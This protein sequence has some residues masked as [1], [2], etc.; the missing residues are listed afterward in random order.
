MP[1]R[2]TRRAFLKLAA[3]SAAAAAVP[4]WAATA[5]E[6]REQAGDGTATVAPVPTSVPAAPEAVPT[7]EVP[8]LA[9]LL[10]ENSVVRPRAAIV[11]MKQRRLVGPMLQPGDSLFTQFT[12][13]A[14]SVAAFMQANDEAPEP[15][16]RQS[17]ATTAAWTE[18]RAF[19][20]GNGWG[21]PLGAVRSSATVVV[22]RRRKRRIQ[23]WLGSAVVGKDIDNMVERHLGNDPVWFVSLD[24]WA[25]VEKLVEDDGNLYGW[26]VVLTDLQP[27]RGYY[28]DVMLCD[29][30]Y[31]V[32]GNRGATIERSDHLNFETDL[33]NWRIV[34]RIDGRPW[35]TAPVNDRSPFV[36]LDGRPWSDSG[37]APDEPPERWMDDRV[38]V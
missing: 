8:D 5:A 36:V 12:L 13:T 31:Y 29:W 21:M 2:L 15:F 19:L 25:D 24:A 33:R 4:K 16:I 1:A 6:A 20:F 3:V 32:I 37:P 7:R 35:L 17:L 14:H 28:G 10:M 26:P 34:D 38:S 23:H 22:P 9:T 18:D 11:P 30:S 27:Q